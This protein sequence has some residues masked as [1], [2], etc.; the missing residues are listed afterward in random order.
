MTGFSIFASIIAMKNLNLLI[1]IVLVVAVA[2]LF[3]LHFNSKPKQ[4]EAPKSPTLESS[5]NTDMVIAFVN[6]DSLTEN[7]EMYKDEFEAASERTFKAEEK[8]T[9]KQRQFEKEAN[10]FQQR[11]Q[12]LT[13]TERESKQE[14]LIK[15]QQELMQLE[16]ELSTDLQRQEAEVSKRIF[17][18]IDVFLKNY[19]QEN[20]FTYVLSYARGGGVWYADSKFDITPEV[21]KALNE[22]YRKQKAK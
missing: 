5:G 17:D 21:L 3:A 14:K 10:E 11:A 20:N 22:N 6:A 4:S 18:T 19:A 8:F 2:L 7:Y 15:Q 9:K 13:I 12:Y 1:N 16:Q